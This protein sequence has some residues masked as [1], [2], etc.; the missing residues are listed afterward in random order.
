MGSSFFVSYVAIWLLVL[1]QGLLVLALLRQL[2]ELRRLVES[3]GAQGEDRLPVGSPAPE[4]EGLDARSGRRVDSHSLNGR[5]GVLIFLSPECGT[6]K[7]LADGLWRPAMDGLPPIITFCQGGQQSCASFVRRLGPEVHVLRDDADEAATRYHVS[8][9]PT[10][11]VIDGE[12][13]IRGYGHPQN[14]E[15]LK[16]LLSRSL[17]TGGAGAEVEEKSR[18]VTS[19]SG[20]S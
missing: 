14:V 1:F 7:D 6:C 10:A 2:A 17:G 18:P 20:A 13:K 5:G 12:Q 8:G 19:A 15:D 9:S 16:R 11:V 3:G 4:F